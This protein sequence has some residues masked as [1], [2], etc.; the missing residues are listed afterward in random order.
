M[1]PLLGELH[2]SCAPT[3]R[4]RSVWFVYDYGMCVQACVC[5]RA[6]VCFAPAGLDLV[7]N[8]LDDYSHWVVH[9]FGK[10]TEKAIEETSLRRMS[11]VKNQ[12]IK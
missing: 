4:V 3:G 6:C 8:L 11:A 9:D 7:N 5:V 12:M 1:Y 2:A 10:P